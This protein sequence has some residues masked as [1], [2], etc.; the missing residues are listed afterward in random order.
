MSFRS[1]SRPMTL[2]FACF[3]NVFR[4]CHSALAW[5]V[6]SLLFHHTVSKLLCAHGF[7][8]VIP[9]LSLDI[10]CWYSAGECCHAPYFHI[11][12]LILVASA[13][14]RCSIWLYAFL[15]HTSICQMI[16]RMSTGLILLI[17]N[18]VLLTGFAVGAFTW[19]LPA[20]GA[21]CSG[22]LTAKSSAPAQ[23]VSIATAEERTISLRL[24]E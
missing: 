24:N 16:G 9:V 22:S 18:A 13:T 14:L 17:C 5:E 6:D 15:S 10:S 7:S 8:L 12:S 11:I 2:K 20:L 21:C 1:L 3:I 19:L 23:A 4:M